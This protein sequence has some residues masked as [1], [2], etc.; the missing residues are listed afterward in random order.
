MSLNQS[1]S[2]N[3]LKMRRLQK[4][5][6]TGAGETADQ[7]RMHSIIAE[8]LSLVLAGQLTAVCILL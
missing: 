2:I 3:L 5:T 4:M 8:D 6:L 1:K 7:V